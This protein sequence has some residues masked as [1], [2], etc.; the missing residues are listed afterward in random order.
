MRAKKSNPA[1]SA[2]GKLAAG[3][4]RFLYQLLAS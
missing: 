2:N 3:S 4:T 1:G